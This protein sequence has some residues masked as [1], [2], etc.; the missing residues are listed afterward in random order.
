MVSLLSYSSLRDDNFE[1]EM[2]QLV[3][4]DATQRTRQRNSSTDAH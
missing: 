2:E 1:L 4:Q 3:G